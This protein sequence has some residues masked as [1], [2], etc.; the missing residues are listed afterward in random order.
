MNEDQENAEKIKGFINELD[1][2]MLLDDLKLDRE[3]EKQRTNFK[4]KTSKQVLNYSQNNQFIYEKEDTK[5]NGKEYLSQIYHHP[6]IP[7]KKAKQLHESLSTSIIKL[8]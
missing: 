1:I 6:V 3:K 2:D 7:T 5:E 4:E 8:D